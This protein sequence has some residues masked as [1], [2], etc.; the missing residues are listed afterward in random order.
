MFTLLFGPLMAAMGL[1]VCWRLVCPLPLPKIWKLALCALIMAGAMKMLLFRLI[2]GSFSI[3]SLPDWLL[4]ASAWWNVAVL[5]LFF[6]LV[7][8]LLAQVLAPCFG[9]C[10]PMHP[11][12]ALLFLCAAM[13]ISA[14][15]VWQGTASPRLRQ[16]DLP[17]AD[18]PQDLEGLRIAHITDTH[19][20]PIFRKERMEELVT[21][22]NDLNPDLVFITG[23]IVDGNV[24][25]L[26]VDAAPLAELR[27]RYGVWA[28]PGNHEYYSGFS[29]WMKQFADFGIRML[30]NE[31][32]VLRINSQALLLAGVSDV[33]A[34]RF[35]LEEPDIGKALA[36]A[37]PDAPRILLAHRPMGSAEHARHGVSLQFSG[38]THGGQALPVQP[39]VKSLNDSYLYGLY[40]VNGMILYVGTGAGLWGGYP[41]RFGVPPEVALFRLIKRSS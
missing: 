8:F 13:L 11:K 25:D 24:Q 15:G 34:A 28:C 23:D 37:P 30:I 26:R 3:N 12:S 33:V 27:P 1:F 18:W 36:G 7:V 38:H 4:L 10:L 35:G 31:H 40:A 21:R 14:H 2:R 39:L 5:A 41:V 6:L 9:A 22:I 29:P 17:L 16:I 32:A 20:G 19:I